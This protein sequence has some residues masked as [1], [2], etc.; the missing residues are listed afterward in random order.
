MEIKGADIVA[1]I[2]S[3]LHEIKKSRKDACAA[4]GLKSSQSITGWKKQNSI[5]I[6]DTALRIADFLGVSYRWLLSGEDDPEAPTPAAMDIAR[7]FDALDAEA[8]RTVRSVISA[9]LK[10][11]QN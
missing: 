4:A 9:Y 3:R 11:P 1:R 7:D 2:D 6:A 8:Q 5:P 10:A